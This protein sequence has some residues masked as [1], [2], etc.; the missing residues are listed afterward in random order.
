MPETS[1]L[2]LAV[3]MGEPA[4]IGPDLALMARRDGADGAPFYV[5]A[6]PALLRMR[7]EACG[8]DVAIVET[9]EDGS[10]EAF[11]KGLPV[12]R[13]ATRAVATAGRPVTATAAAVIEAIDRAVAAVHAGKARA[14]TT[15]PIMKNVLYRAGFAH[16]G[17]TEYLGELAKHFWSRPVA[18]VMMIWSPIVA[19][20]P[21][22]I[23]IPLAQVPTTLTEA[24]IVETAI[25]VARDLATRF[26]LEHPRL[27]LAGLNPHAGENGALGH[28]DASMIVPAVARLRAAGID[29]RGPLPAD[30]I[31]HERA[32]QTYDVALCMYHDQALAPAKALAFDEAVNVTLGL[33]FVRT[34][35]DHGTAFDLAGTGPANPSSFLASLA[36]AD[37]LSR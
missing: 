20:V 2:P 34:S 16:P 33:P 12:V 35:P 13:L 36:L 8:I 25:V 6:D 14:V 5:L 17:H 21:V 22:T 27:A 29:A 30:T 3:T 19:V 32:R 24:M 1:L 23:H 26:G 37:R 28:E 4:G 15:A 7:A 31:F 11:R 9:D 18:P 10:V